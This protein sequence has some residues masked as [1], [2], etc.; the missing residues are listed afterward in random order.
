MKKTMLSLM[1]LVALTA[2]GGG[3]DE[4][5]A[6]GDTATMDTTTAAAPAEGTA[7]APAAAPG[8]GAVTDPQIAGIVVAANEVDIAAGELAQS[9]AANP[10][11]K[12]FAQRM[13]TDHSGVNK[14]ASDL[15]TK[16]GVT[17]EESP[18]SQ[19]LRQGGE[20][21]RSNL[22][23]QS[24]AA[25]DRAYIAQEVAYHQAVLDAINNTLIPNAQNAE[26]KALLQQTA[27]A[28]QAHLEHARKL[29][30]SLGGS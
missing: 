26:L 17:P 16:L 30:G 7:Q 8:G 11:V 20:Q 6:G 13:I 29:Q 2:C 15:V 12:E 4:G 19:Q 14:A 5:Q 3:Q 21:N 25:F 9:K 18:V 23:G 24:G 28:V 1:M 10:Q 27:P 22:Q